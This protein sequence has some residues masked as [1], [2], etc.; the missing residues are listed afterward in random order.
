MVKMVREVFIR[1]ACLFLRGSRRAGTRN[2]QAIEELGKSSSPSS[3]RTGKALVFWAT[4]EVT[5]P[6]KM[7]EDR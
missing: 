5:M 3:P 1:A 7:G 2:Q 4:G 6:V